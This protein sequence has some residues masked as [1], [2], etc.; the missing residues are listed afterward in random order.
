MNTSQ[1]KIRQPISLLVI[2][3]D[4]LVRRRL[5]SELTAP[6]KIIVVGE[7]ED[8]SSG[9]RL[10]DALRPDITFLEWELGFCDAFA[11]VSTIRWADNRARIILFSALTRQTNIVPGL[12]AG[13][14][15]CLRKSASI[16]EIASAIEDVHTG[17]RYLAPEA[18]AQLTQSVQGSGLTRRERQIIRLLAKALT[19]REIGARLGIAESTVKSHMNG[20]LMNLNAR[21]RY[22]ALEVAIQT[23]VVG[24]R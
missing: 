13:A 19:N 17:K 14:V 23:G 15:G 5:N 21:T 22:E 3:A 12:R 11:A 16:E 8:A 20:I 10:W 6:G 2:N 4:A 18:L 24:P 7:A 1:V 9:V